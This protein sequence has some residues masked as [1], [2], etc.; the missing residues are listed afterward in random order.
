MTTDGPVG[1]WAGVDS[2][3]RGK[4]P[5]GLQP[6]AFDHSAT[7]PAEIE[8][9]G[10]LMRTPQA[11][12]ILRGY[13]R[14]LRASPGFEVPHVKRCDT[15]SRA[16]SD[17]RRAAPACLQLAAATTQPPSHVPTPKGGTAKPRYVGRGW[18]RTTAGKYR[19]V[20]SLLPSTTRPPAPAPFGTHIQPPKARHRHA[21]G[22]PYT[23]ARAAERLP[24]P[25][26]T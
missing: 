19:Q 24:R 15:L 17:H 22:P 16:A 11:Q 8:P 9:R 4:I 20:Y 13:R 18:I 23:K 5:A 12:S 1:C 21:P 3:H 6:A 7:R 14:A 2:D 10:T 26:H 25:A